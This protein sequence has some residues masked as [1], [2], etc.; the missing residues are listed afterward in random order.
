MEF[1][2]KGNNIMWVIDLPHDTFR[3]HNNAKCC[4]VIIQKGVEQQEYI[5]MAVAQ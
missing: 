1:M 3:P 4:A 2:F 5:N